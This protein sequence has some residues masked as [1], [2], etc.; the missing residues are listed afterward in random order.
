MPSSTFPSF[1]V[2]KFPL[3]S[4]S[5]FLKTVNSF[6]IFLTPDYFAYLSLLSTCPL[7]PS[8][9]IAGEY[10]ALWVPDHLSY[11]TWHLPSL[12]F[13]SVAWSHSISPCIFGHC[14]TQPS[15]LRNAILSQHFTWA[16]VWC[17][18]PAFL[19]RQLSHMPQLWWGEGPVNCISAIQGAFQEKVHMFSHTL[20]QLLDLS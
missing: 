11:S 10:K 18:N 9:F 17:S 6:H 14:R 20:L 3:V 12:T 2:H 16:T 15:L 1:T 13:L 4:C 19:P 8:I 5:A 7:S